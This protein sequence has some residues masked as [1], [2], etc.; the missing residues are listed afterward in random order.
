MGNLLIS[1]PKYAGSGIVLEVQINA[2]N[3]GNVNVCPGDRRLRRPAT[4]ASH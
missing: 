1:E 3:F 2:V 4:C